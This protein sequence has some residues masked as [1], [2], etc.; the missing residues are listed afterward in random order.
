MSPKAITEEEQKKLL[1]DMLNHIDKRCREKG[2]TYW[3]FWG[4]LLGVIRHKGMI[5]W[6]D[7]IDI[8]MPREDYEKFREDVRDNPLASNIHFVDNT[9]PISS[10]YP[11][12]FGKICRSD[13][14]I[15]YPSYGDEYEMEVSIDVFPM[16]GVSE[17]EKERT[18]L[19]DKLD[20]LT[21]YINRCVYMPAKD[22][23]STLR[24]LLAL[25][26]RKSRQIFLYDKWLKQKTKII[27][28]YKTFKNSKY[29][30]FPSNIN[31]RGRRLVFE[32]K[33]FETIYME[34]EGKMM[35]VP[36][37]YDDILEIV[38]PNYMELPPVEERVSH[39]D[40]TSVEWR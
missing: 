16:D 15:R 11:N 39:H 20:M 28:S 36:A 4:T 10:F 32:K 17:D 9:H 38:F 31:E 26:R 6:D 29:C 37:G 8:A 13:T 30:G 27:D 1:F 24:Y 25:A 33:W 22:G 2:Y 23:R 34:F 7:D 3:L 19:T 5:P 21:S 12:A 18:E 14:I 40:Y 35:P